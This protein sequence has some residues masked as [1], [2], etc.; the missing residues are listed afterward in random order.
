MT[1]NRLQVFVFSKFTPFVPPLLKIE[2]DD[3]PT[4]F[5]FSRQEKGLGK[6]VEKKSCINLISHFLML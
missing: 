2:G 3:H 4:L 6:G 1:N 5:P